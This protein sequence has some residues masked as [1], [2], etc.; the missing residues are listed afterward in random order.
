MKE[1]VV[2]ENGFTPWRGQSVVREGEQESTARPSAQRSNILGRLKSGSGGDR[3][4]WGHGRSKTKPKAETLP[5]ESGALEN[6][7][8]RPHVLFWEAGGE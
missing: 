3:E 4:P 6:S 2:S 1:N 7:W 5:L 8:K